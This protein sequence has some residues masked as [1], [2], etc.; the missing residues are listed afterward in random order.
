MP[1]PGKKNVPN[2]ASDLPPKLPSTSEAL[3]RAILLLGNR[4]KTEL[5]D[6][7]RCE[8]VELLGSYPSTEQAGAWKQRLKQLV[9]QRS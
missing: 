9:K 6:K 3:Q 4:T 5:T 7:S 8:L 2:P 1:I